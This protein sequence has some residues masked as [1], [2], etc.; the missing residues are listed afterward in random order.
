MRANVHLDIVP[1]QLYNVERLEYVKLLGVFIDSKLSFCEHVER[2]LCICNQR[3]Y[4]LSQ[5]RKQ[6]LSDKCIGVVYDAIVLY[7]MLYALSGCTVH[8]FSVIARSHGLWACINRKRVHAARAQGGGHRPVNIFKIFVH[9]DDFMSGDWYFP[10]DP[11]M[12]YFHRNTETNKAEF[13]ISGDELDSVGYILATAHQVLTETHQQ[14]THDDH[15]HHQEFLFWAVAQRT[16]DANPQCGPG[17]MRGYRFWL[18][19]P[20]TFLILRN[21]PPDSW[22]VCFTVRGLSDTF[23]RVP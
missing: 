19:K 7:K 2:L 6:S 10:K 20:L 15:W 23:A 4:L 3:L 22:E 13:R 11:K 14:S 21:L 18:Q 8:A 12:W 9:F 16:G 17:P 5:T 1:A